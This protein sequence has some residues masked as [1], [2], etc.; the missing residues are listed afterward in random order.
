[1]LRRLLSILVLVAS[2]KS[3]DAKDWAEKTYGVAQAREIRQVAEK[4]YGERVL[5]STVKAP[6]NDGYL[7]RPF[8]VFR[9]PGGVGP[10][11]IDPTL[12]YHPINRTLG[13]VA[14]SI[15]DMHGLA[16]VRY[17]DTFTQTGWI[18][19][20]DHSYVQ[21]GSWSVVTVVALIDLDSKSAKLLALDGHDD[22]TLADALTSLPSLP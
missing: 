20:R 12:V 17:V 15:H 22:D 11:T 9:V 5:R 14:T 13:R 19:K 3:T 16:V 7:P 8:V 6:G 2:C 21:T 4:A 10:E 1:M 18:R